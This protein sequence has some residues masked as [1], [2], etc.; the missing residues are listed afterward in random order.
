MGDAGDEGAGPVGEPGQRVEGPP[1]LAVDVGVEVVADRR[2]QRVEGD[3]R[4]VILPDRVFYE[5]VVGRQAEGDGAAFT[6]S[7]SAR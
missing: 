7:T 4:D 5:L 1:H 2:H 6:A 3:Q